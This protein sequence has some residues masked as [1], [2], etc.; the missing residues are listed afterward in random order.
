MLQQMKYTGRRFHSYFYMKS[1]SSDKKLD[2]QDSVTPCKLHAEHVILT[3]C[4]QNTQNL[5]L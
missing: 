2:L 5:I 1:H 3:V 4:G